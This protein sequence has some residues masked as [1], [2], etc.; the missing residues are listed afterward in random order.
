MTRMGSDGSG[1]SSD[2]TV[3]IHE[4]VTGGG[5]ADEDLPASLAREGRAMRRALAGDFA[6]A[7]GVRV[8]MTADPREPD[9]DASGPWEVVRIGPGQEL[10]RV[11]ELAT[12]VDCTLIIAPETG[13]ILFDRTR[14]LDRIGARSLGCSP[15]AVA[16]AGNVLLTLDRL[17]H[18]GVRTPP[19]R[20]V[21]PRQGW[22][23]RMT[24]PLEELGRVCP[25]VEIPE[26][27]TDCPPHQAAEAEIDHPC[28]LK[29]VDGAGAVQS[30][31]LAGETPW[32]DPSWSPEVAVLQPWIEG[33]HRSVSVLVSNGGRPALIGCASQRISVD[34]GRISYVGGE[35][36]LPIGPA[37]LR[38][39]DRVIGTLP[40]LRGW[41][42]I[43]WIDDGLGDPI[44]L[45]VN[46]RPTT[47]VVGFL[48]L[49]PPG[50][51]A[52]TWLGLFDDPTTPLTALLA[53]RVQSAVGRPVSF[54]PNGTLSSPRDG[55]GS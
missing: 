55:A 17:R 19:T 18:A 34:R 39:V 29:P 40:G 23:R 36:P 27:L 44:V 9:E 25:F 47:S 54:D 6:A 53:E 20:V 50:M 46:P 49:L 48:A 33:K 14:M 24:F 45:E 41:V 52:Q 15:E 1:L 51:L 35:A 10:P 26:P 8:I 3:L 13:G 32:P 11:A 22:P 38:M 12:G 5:L 31:V 16:V 30:F 7:P 42:G 37:I 28:V 21:T 4:F 43:D 2:R